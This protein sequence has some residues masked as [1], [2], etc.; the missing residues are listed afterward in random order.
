MIV[1][2]DVTQDCIDRGHPNDACDCPVFHAILDAMPWLD[3][4]LVAVDREYV[5]LA[6]EDTADLPGDAQAWLAA[7]DSLRPVE[8]FRFDLE[9]PD[10][11]VPAGAAP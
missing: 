1:T 10:R 8:P 7:Y 9:I 5:V 3:P 4:L 11:L 6:A 2:V